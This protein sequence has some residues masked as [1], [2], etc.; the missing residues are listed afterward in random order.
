MGGLAERAMPPGMSP[1]WSRGNFNL[2]SQLSALQRQSSSPELVSSHFP[3]GV[4][5]PIAFPVTGSSLMGC[6]VSVLQ[7][8]TPVPCQVPVANHFPLGL[9]ET[10]AALVWPVKRLGRSG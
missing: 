9:I 10:E 7:T 3:S 4:K 2:G 6:Q 5:T 8:F 1:A